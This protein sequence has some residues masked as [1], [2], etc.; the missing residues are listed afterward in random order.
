MLSA[1]WHSRCSLAVFEMN[2]L[3]ILAILIAVYFVALVVSV[4]LQ[5]GGDKRAQRTT[6]KKALIESRIIVGIFCAVAGVGVLL[7]N[8]IIIICGVLF[9]VVMFYRSGKAWQKPS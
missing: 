6:L 1:F 2:W 9:G 3:I 5:S 4:R 7:K 8:Q